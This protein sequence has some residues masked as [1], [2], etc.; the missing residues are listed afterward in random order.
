MS[1]FCCKNKKIT[2]AVILGL[3]LCVYF[4]NFF[5]WMQKQNKIGYK[6][7]TNCHQKI[8]AAVILGL[9]AL[10]PFLLLLLPGDLNPLNNRR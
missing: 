3:K 6:N 4:E 2:A 7:K 9:I 1:L 10:L 5:V 8:A